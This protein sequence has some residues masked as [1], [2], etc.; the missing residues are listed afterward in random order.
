MVDYF[1]F[2]REVFYMKQFLN[3]PA[4]SSLKYSFIYVQHDVFCDTTQCAL[5]CMKHSSYED[6]CFCGIAHKVKNSTDIIVLYQPICLLIKNWKLM[7]IKGNNIL[8][9][10]MSTLS[11][12]PSL[13]S[14]S[15][16]HFHSSGIQRPEL[17]WNSVSLL[18]F[19]WSAVIP[20]TFEIH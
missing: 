2:L 15:P 18:H 16:S 5:L 6:I 13:Q 7:N 1:S 17:H 3:N 8:H 14:V 10:A 12:A 19:R 9:P 20:N 11:S 4:V